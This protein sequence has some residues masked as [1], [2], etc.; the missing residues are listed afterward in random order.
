VCRTDEALEVLVSPAA[1]SRAIARGSTP[2]EL[3]ERLMAVAELTP[4]LKEL[5]DHASVVVG[6]GALV[7][8]GAFLWVDNP[9]V[10]EMLR[11]A[12]TTVEFFVDPSPPGGLL[13][14]AGVD[15]E[16]LVRRCRGLGVEIDVAQDLTLR[17]SRGSNRAFTP[18]PTAV[19][20]RDP[21]EGSSRSGTRAVRRSTPAAM[22]RTP[23][24]PRAK[25]IGFERLCAA[26]KAR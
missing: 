20:G 5:L 18:P 17:A 10:R 21:T 26:A 11:Q 1:I 25:A 22:S 24:P 12:R 8:V 6:K 16:R 14:A 2:D 4:E 13:V 15:L 23:D 3:R 7:A 19:A 9:D